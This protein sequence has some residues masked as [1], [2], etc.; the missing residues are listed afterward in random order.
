MVQR[1][2]AIF[3]VGYDFTADVLHKLIAYLHLL[4]IETDIFFHIRFT[5][6]FRQSILN[7]D[8]E[9]DTVQASQRAV[10]HVFLQL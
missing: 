1:N 5:S 9:V 7:E 8:H 3:K 10:L 6:G 2:S 4:I